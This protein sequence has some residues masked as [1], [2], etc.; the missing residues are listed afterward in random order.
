MTTV[1]VAPRPRS[2]VHSIDFSSGVQSATLFGDV[3][4]SHTRDGGT[5]SFIENR[6]TCGAVSKY[7]S[8]HGF[9][10]YQRAIRSSVLREVLLAGPDELPERRLVDRSERLHHRRQPRAGLERDRPGEERAVAVRLEL[11]V[12]GEAAQ[13]GTVRR[14]DE[15]RVALPIVPAEE[16]LPDGHRAQRQDDL[17]G[18]ADTERPQRG[19]PQ[20]PDAEAPRPHTLVRSQR[21]PHP[22]RRCREPRR[23]PVDL[24]RLGERRVVRTLELVPAG[25][26]DSLPQSI[27]NSVLS[28][29]IAKYTAKT[30]ATIHIRTC[31]CRA[32]PVAALS[33]T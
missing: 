14:G 5:G 29:S 27:P 4:D 19:P 23:E 25:H 9:I 13:T 30:I 20:R 31:T 28:G 3:N 33:T 26:G 32:L 16:L 2:D 7:D 10:W 24:A 12:L 15:E 11:V 1:R 8:S 17:A 22:R 6:Y 21:L 18:R